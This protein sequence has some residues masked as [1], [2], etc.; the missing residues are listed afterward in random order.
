MSYSHKPVLLKEVIEFLN[1]QTGAKY[2]DATVGGGGYAIE[3]LKL[4]GIVLG[5]DLDKDAIDYIK[6]KFKIDKELVLARG[7]FAEIKNIAEEN[8]FTDIEGVVFD[9]GLSSYQIEESGRGF[10]FLRDEPLDMRMD[11]GGSGFTAADIVNKWSKEELYELFTK[12]GE[13]R[14]SHPIIH[15]IIRARRI[16][17]IKSSLELAKI[18]SE[19]VPEK[20][21][22][23]PATKVF[24]ALRIAVNDEINNLKRGISG[25]FGVLN[26]GGRIAVV[27]FQS[28]EDRIV[29][30]DFRNYQKEGRGRII[31]KKP[32]IASQEE[33]KSNRRA[34]SAKLRVIEKI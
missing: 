19:A 6:N 20:S 10:S 25:A 30:N 7:N 26:R 16:K 33:I 29:K 34:R 13:E 11:S 22:I 21:G 31:T 15:N 18:V 2:I 9:L 4:G 5:I 32:I 3:I 1:V 28:L 12:M 27:S 8:G 14:F 17:P 24:Q 23:H